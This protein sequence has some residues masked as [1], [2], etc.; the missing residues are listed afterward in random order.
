MAF[1]HFSVVIKKT[2]FNGRTNQ[3]RAAL[4]F[5]FGE[6]GQKFLSKD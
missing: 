1:F 6:G 2:K 3:R 5:F 4:V